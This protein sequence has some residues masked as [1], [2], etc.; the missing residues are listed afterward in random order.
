MTIYDVANGLYGLS[1]TAGMNQRY[2]QELLGRCD[3]REWI[4]LVAGLTLLAL[5]LLFVCIANRRQ[6][7]NE[8]NRLAA[9]LLFV[10]AITN[11]WQGVYI[12][13]EQSRSESRVLLARWSD[14]RTDADAAMAQCDALPDENAPA[15]PLLIARL[16][17]L[18]SRNNEINATE[19]PAD[20]ALLEKVDGDERQSRTGKREWEATPEWEPPK[21][22][23]PGKSKSKEE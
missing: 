11:V 10:I 6:W 20:E 22:D 14:L 23:D 7:S 4:A 21:Y 17:Q 3:V 8:F 18:E 1:F 16:Q 12:S 13:I 5:N 19:G 9:G 15:D 2:Y